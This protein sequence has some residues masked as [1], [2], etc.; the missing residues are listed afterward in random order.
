MRAI[1]GHLRTLPRDQQDAV[2]LLHWA[3]L[4]YEEAAT[5][6][7]VSAGT[8]RSRM[9]RARGS[10]GTRHEPTTSCGRSQGSALTVTV[11]MESLPPE[12]DLPPTRLMRS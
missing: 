3:G 9:A 6:L 11:K 1:L 8:I 5:A 4:S 2:A 12:F 7:S 10:C